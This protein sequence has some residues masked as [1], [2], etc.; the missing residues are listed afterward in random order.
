MNAEGI[1][2]KIPFIRL[3]QRSNSAEKK[4]SH[5]IG[6]LEDNNQTRRFEPLIEILKIN[7]T[8]ISRDALDKTNGAIVGALFGVAAFG[9]GLLI[10]PSSYRVMLSS[11]YAGLGLI[12]SSMIYAGTNK[13]VFFIN[14][15]EELLGA[16]EKGT[17]GNSI[18]DQ[19]F[20]N[21]V[22]NLNRNIP[23][24]RGKRRK[25]IPFG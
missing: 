6:T 25:L 7:K 17:Q 13:E 19:I 2:G 15:T 20:G 23:N 12:L 18:H 14:R 4:L 1:A 5:A 24:I 8:N 22:T 9:V 21:N 3:I 10:D 11:F 16:I